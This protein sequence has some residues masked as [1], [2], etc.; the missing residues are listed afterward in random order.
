MG[1][2]KH[3]KGSGNTSNGAKNERIQKNP[4]EKTE[5]TVTVEPEE[6][7]TAED[8][9][10]TETEALAETSAD[11]KT[12]TKRKK[13]AGKGK[14]KE[15]SAAVDEKPRKET[16][17]DIL[18]EADKI[19]S[20]GK[21]FKWN[22]FSISVAAGIAILLFAFGLLTGL[23]MAGYFEEEPADNVPTPT[24]TVTADSYWNDREKEQQNEQ[25][26]DP[27]NQQEEPGEQGNPA[28]SETAADPTI[29]PVPT[30]KG[31]IAI[32]P[33]HQKKGNYDTEPNG[34][35]STEMKAK[36]SSGTQGVVTRLEEYELN[37]Q[38]SLKLRDALIEDGYEV[39]MTRETNDVNLSNVERAVIANDAGVD[40]F[41]R[42]HADGSDDKSV[43]GV[44]T[45]CQT[46][47]NKYNSDMYEQSRNLSDCILDAVC[48]STGALKRKVWETDTMTGI[49][50]VTV[51]VTI[52]EM[53]YMSNPAEDRLMATDEYQQ[54]IVEG[55]V[56]GLNKFMGYE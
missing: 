5:Q 29:T 37:L 25:Q 51:P 38:V 56:N 21:G 18:N 27:V 7:Q 49:N 45:I 30:P 53:G 11:V 4:Q 42:I 8:T 9:A 16:I 19:M 36:V 35:G 50:W 17:E 14:R 52:L 22:A 54:K 32:D 20:K 40:A 28:E 3:K 12:E 2:K 55:I 43:H 15:S 13:K 31:L 48:E 47:K 44:M 26:N 10:A 24:P 33:G 34:P 23:S 41:I 6:T 1:S 39:I 46:P